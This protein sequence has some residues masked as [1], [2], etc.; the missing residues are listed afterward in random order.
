[1]KDMMPRVI[2]HEP[3]YIIKAK[4][5]GYDWITKKE[6]E[7]RDKIKQGMKNSF[8]KIGRPKKV[9]DETLKKAYSKWLSGQITQRE[10]AEIFNLSE[11]TVSRRFQKFGEKQPK[12]Q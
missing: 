6:K 8:K 5:G 9:D 4:G 10:I 7:R 12:C 1:M 3:V 11:R 2:Q